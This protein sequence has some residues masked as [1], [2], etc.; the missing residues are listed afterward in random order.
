[1]SREITPKIYDEHVLSQGLQFQVDTYY[2]PKEA[3]LKRR[4]AVV[5]D[6][7]GPKSYDKILDV[8]CGVG[9]FA[10]HSAK[11]AAQA[12]GI[13]YSGESI[14]AAATLVKRFAMEDKVKFIVANATKLPFKDS[15]FDKIIASDFIEH[16]NLKEKGEFL[17]Q[18]RRVLRA[19]GIA[20]VFT[21]NRTREKISDI[22]W[23]IRAF[24]LGDKVPVNDLHFGLTDSRE[25]ESLLK[26][27]DLNFKL[28]YVDI[29]R[30][31]IARLPLIRN[32]LSLN[33]LWTIEKQ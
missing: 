13:D 30:P 25:F 16:I 27:Y 8:G 33:L 24:L 14:A 19:G 4:I 18:M 9:T 31:Y 17:S 6:A 7:L 22:Y 23:K 10:F 2:Q 11:A 26:S 21:P 20:V 29:T 28:K 15:S 5:M 32:F 12:V 1:M 3:S